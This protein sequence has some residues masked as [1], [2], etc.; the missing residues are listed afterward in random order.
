MIDAEDTVRKASCDARDD[1]RE[2]RAKVTH[3]AVGNNFDEA[4]LALGRDE[5][6]VS[7]GRFVSALDA[8]RGRGLVPRVSPRWL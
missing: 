1:G 2:A 7:D 6:F 5:S 4:Y 8:A 3:G